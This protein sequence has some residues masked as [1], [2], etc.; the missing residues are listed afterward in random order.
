MSKATVSL[1]DICTTSVAT[2][3]CFV[4]NRDLCSEHDFG[5]EHSDFE[6]RVWI[7]NS[8]FCDELYE[9][10]NIA[11]VCV[12]CSDKLKEQPF[13]IPQ[14]AIDIIQDAIDTWKDLLNEQHNN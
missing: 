7:Y 10:N 12:Y 1:C 13:E 3:K 6:I 14:R 5:G 8:H 2:S 9:R 4:C 11:S